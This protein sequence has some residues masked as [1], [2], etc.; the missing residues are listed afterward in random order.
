MYVVMWSAGVVV[1]WSVGVVVVWDVRGYRCKC[2][3]KCEC[4]GD[5]RDFENVA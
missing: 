1:M 4:D 5:V 2:G 3:V